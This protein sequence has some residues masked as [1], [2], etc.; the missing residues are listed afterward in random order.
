MPTVIKSETQFAWA[1][2][3]TD[4]SYVRGTMVLAYSLHSVGS[5]YPLEVLI[6]EKISSSDIELIKKPSP[7]IKI[8]KVQSFKPKSNAIQNYAF[9]RFL[10]NWIK[11]RCFELTDYDYVALLDSDMLVTENFDH[12]LNNAQHQLSKWTGKLNPDEIH[13]LAAHACVCNPMRKPTYPEWWNPSN[14]AYTKCD[15]VQDIVCVNKS[16]V[17]TQNIDELDVGG[18]ILAKRYFNTGLFIVAPNMD[19]ASQLIQKV[20]NTPDLTSFHFAEQDFLSRIFKDH[21]APLPLSVNFLKT[22]IFAHP[23]LYQLD[24]IHNIHYIMD[25]PWN[26]DL[27]HPD[28]VTNPFREMYQLW[29]NTF[30]SM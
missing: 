29:W 13:I 23:N 26:V 27:T 24:E 18:S 15:K 4:P 21:W 19:L 30:K 11:L 22:I 7:N 3:L 28:T 6:N 1:T 8:R 16:K 2:L 9:E 10:E 14:C 17:T 5:I 25:K 12:L 20:H